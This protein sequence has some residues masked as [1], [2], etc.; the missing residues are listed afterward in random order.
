MTSRPWAGAAGSEKRFPL[1][2]ILPLLS[3]LHF[4]GLLAAHAALP[5]FHAV[6]F[7]AIRTRC[8]SIAASSTVEASAT[9]HD[10]RNAFPPRHI[11]VR[12]RSD[13]AQSPR[14][15]PADPTFSLLSPQAIEVHNSVPYCDSVVARGGPGK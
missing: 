10:V 5:H 11:S 6:V 8:D 15:A 14:L 7:Q 1:K 13:I 2:E 9:S 4:E 12:T 3:V